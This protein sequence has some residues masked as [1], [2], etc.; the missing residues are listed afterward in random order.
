MVYREHIR[1]LY[2]C[3]KN[4]CACCCFFYFSSEHIRVLLFF[5]FPQNTYAFYVVLVTEHIRVLIIR[6]YRTQKHTKAH[7]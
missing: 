6:G 1:V 4:T 7:I 3:V 5:F 2:S